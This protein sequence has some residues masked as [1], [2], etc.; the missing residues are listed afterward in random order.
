[1]ARCV[2]GPHPPRF[3]ARRG[4]DPDRLEA[5]ERRF[6][7]GHT[8]VVALYP[9]A[10]G[11]ERGELVAIMGPSGSG[12]TT[13][14][15]LVGGLDRRPAAGSL[16]QDVGNCRRSCHARRRTVGYVFQDL[17]LLAGLTARENV[18]APARSSTPCRDRAGPG[19]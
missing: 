2:G 12:K 9:T 4:D 17:N 5:A 18:S 15:S 16:G 7:T 1:M 19:S 3:C 10:L 8:E 13:L 11:V 14:L 6:G